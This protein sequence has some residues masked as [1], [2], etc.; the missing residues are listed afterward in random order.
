MLKLRIIQAAKGDC[1]VLV[2]GT[3]PAHPRYM[4]ID[5]GP[6]GVYRPYLAPELARIRAAGGRLDHVVLSHI[7]DDH[8]R[9]LL[10][11]LNAKRDGGWDLAIGELWHNT[12][13]QTMGTE[14][15]SQ[16]ADAMLEDMAASRGSDG[17]PDTLLM[18]LDA[19]S[20]NQ[21]DKLT[22]LAE[23][24]EIP[25][26]P[27]FPPLEPTAGPRGLVCA[28]TATKLLRLD[29]LTLRVAGPNR[30]NLARLRQ[31]WDAWLA[32]RTARGLDTSYANLSSLMFLVQTPNRKRI[33][34]TGDGR[35]DEVVDALTKARVLNSRI[36]Q[37]QVDVLKLPHHGS[38]RNA[39]PEFFR[40][41]IATHYIISADGQHD[42]PDI[43]TLR[44]LTDARKPDRQPYYIW[45]TN[46]TQSTVDFRAERPPSAEYRYR[47]VQLPYD[48]PAADQVLE[49]DL[50]APDPAAKYP[51]L[52]GPYRPV[53]IS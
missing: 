48:T 10:D 47:F 28:E 52:P 17:Q 33:L 9:G 7:D 39:T 2:Y 23:E 49:I 31:E 3:D 19:R 1:L 18:D 20:I 44:V 32:A 50:D 4:L 41:I 22:T 38:I 14:R 16:V 26:N 25:I 15:A 43:E 21:G 12:F 13:S 53:K 11:F 24:L 40:T 5:G 37:L 27:N 42:N 45:I 6:S 34:F 36:K 30:K 35:P 8:V 46:E 29:G 51:P